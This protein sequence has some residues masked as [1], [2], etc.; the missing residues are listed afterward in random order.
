MTIKKSLVKITYAA[1]Q[2]FFYDAQEFCSV[3]LARNVSCMYLLSC[4]QRNDL[5]KT[6]IPELFLYARPHH[7]SLPRPRNLLMRS[8]LAYWLL[9]Q[10]TVTKKLAS[11]RFNRNSL[12]VVN[13]VSSRIIGKYR[14]YCKKVE[15]IT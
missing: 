3:S 12:R 6:K 1:M 11:R 8:C 14:A 7:I 13:I 5:G 9:S 2:T 10:L 15:F 4:Y